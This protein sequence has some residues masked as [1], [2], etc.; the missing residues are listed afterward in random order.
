MSIINLLDFKPL[1]DA[2][3]S[4]VSLEEKVDVPFEIKRVYY[5]CLLIKP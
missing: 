1:G 3:G 5:I 2:R 4:L